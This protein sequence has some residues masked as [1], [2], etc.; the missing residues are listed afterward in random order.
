MFQL[1]GDSRGCRGGGGR[2]ED[3]K[4]EREDRQCR[5]RD[6]R[7]VRPERG[8]QQG[9][10]SFRFCQGS[11]L[12]RFGSLDQNNKQYRQKVSRTKQREKRGR[13]AHCFDMVFE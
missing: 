5:V 4:I 3:I 11:R 9:C 12:M 13:I 1:V 8:L 6:V 2:H 10:Q 7:V